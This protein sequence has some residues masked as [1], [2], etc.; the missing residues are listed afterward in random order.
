MKEEAVI[1]ANV[2]QTFKRFGLQAPA[3]NG[4]VDENGFD[5]SII[6]SYSV[7]LQQKLGL[8]GD[9]IRLHRGE[10]LF[11]RQPNK[12]LVVPAA[13][14]PNTPLP[15]QEAPP[16][17]HKSWSEAFP[18]LIRDVAKGQRAGEYLILEGDL[19][20]RLL[21]S[22]QIFLS[23]F[24]GAPKDGKPLTECARIVHDRSPSPGARA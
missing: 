13:E 16:A 4:P 24:S 5:T 2:A 18:L 7:F 10:D 20:P 8:L 9:L 19:L 11:D 3:T 17:N 22:K 15:V 23:P 14:F 1:R 6:K 12:H 21:A